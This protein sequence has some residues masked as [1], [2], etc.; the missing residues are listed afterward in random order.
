MAHRNYPTL[1]RLLGLSWLEY[2]IECESLRQPPKRI[3]TYIGALAELERALKTTK[4][5]LRDDPK[6][7][8]L[9]DFLRSGIIDEKWGY[10]EHAFAMV[11][12]IERIANRFRDNPLELFPPI[13]NDDTEIDF[14]LQ[15]QDQWIYFEVKASPMF[16]FEGEFLNTKLEKEISRKISKLNSKLFFV[17]CFT[18]LKPD[19]MDANAFYEFLKSATKKIK[20]SKTQMFPVLLNYP[21]D[22]QPVVQVLIVDERKPLTKPS[23][24]SAE[25]WQRTVEVITVS[26]EGSRGENHTFVHFAPPGYDLKKRLENLM[27]HAADQMDR[28][29]PN[30]LIIYTREVVLGSIDEVY[31]NCAD[32]FREHNYTIIDAVVMNVPD[33]AQN[34]RRRLFERRN[35][36]L[37]VPINS[38]L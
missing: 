3:S 15:I 2:M 11:K 28:N 12:E 17:I 10:F 32:L 14:R 8:I 21:S 31:G 27:R 20:D 29:N 23:G 1:R 19:Q 6:F 5:K 34:I 30:V 18:D 38:L 4:E 37:P 25:S 26:I 13:E 36:K 9:L 35:S 33:P 22:Y 7:Q 16:S 24:A